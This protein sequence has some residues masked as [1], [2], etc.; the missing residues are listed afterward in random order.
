MIGKIIELCKKYREII[1]YVIVGGMTTL[2]YFAT[3]AIFKYFGVHYAINT[4]ISWLAAVLFAFI[5][6]KIIVFRSR[7]KKGTFIELAKFIS[8]RLL[9]L[10]IDVFFTFL[11]IDVFNL[12]EWI[13]KISVQ[14]II[15]VLNYVFSK[16]FVFNSKK[17]IQR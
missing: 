9:T 15:P 7:R 11:L 3:Y 14:F 2:V 1:S 8:A 10:G 6:N 12:T 13:S 17:Q 5:T 4:C 16:V